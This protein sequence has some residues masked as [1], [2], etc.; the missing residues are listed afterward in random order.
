[1]TR[2]RWFRGFMTVLVAACM[3]ALSGVLSA[4]GN[5]ENAFERV[6][7]VQ[8]RNTERMLAKPGVVGTA[9]GMDEEGRHVVLIL[10]ERGNVPDIPADLEGIP[11]RRIVTGTINALPKGGSGKPPSSN[12][13]TP[14]PPTSLAAVARSSSQIDLTWTDNS[15]NETG[16]RIERTGGGASASI[17]VRRNV[18][19]YSDTGLSASTPYTY[20]VCAYNDAGDSAY[21]NLASATTSA[22]S[23]SVPAAPSGLTATAVSST[24]IDL[25][26]TDNADNE[27][28]FKIERALDGVSF[29]QIATRGADVTTYSNSGL[30]ASTTYT[31]RVRAYNAAGNSSYS[32]PDS[33]T[34]DAAATP[35]DPSDRF[36]R[37]VP[38]GVSTGHPSITAGTISCR[39]KSGGTLYVLSNNHVYAASNTAGIGDAVIQP[40]TYDKGTS[41]DDDIAHLSAYREILWSTWPFITYNTVDAAIAEIILDDGVPRVGNATPA[42]GYGTPNSTTAPVSSLQIGQA[43]QKYGRTTRLTHGTIQG[44]NATIGV[45]YGGGHIAYFQHQIM[46]EPGSFSAGGDSGSLIVTD[47]ADCKPVGL[48]FA[49]SNTATYANPIDL[50]L[51]EFGV[52]IDG[53]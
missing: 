4:Q 33:A 8:E 18:T 42:G 41:P 7:E 21:S 30:T 34:T 27:T 43:V 47:D 52:T 31:Y 12:P 40:G 5:S 1:M 23:G 37:P 50:V 19:N 29:T 53:R 49:G 6:K 3:L 25:A 24:Q 22:A 16:F 35:T 46:I 26:W 45:D 17:T 39:V 9:V 51:G 13:K 32:D 11:V 10:L 15:K 14:N 38:T 44:L 20:K 48:L 36:P 28:G 2:R